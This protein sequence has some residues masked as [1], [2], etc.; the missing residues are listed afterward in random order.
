MGDHG[1]AVRLKSCVLHAALT[2]FHTLFIP[3]K[4]NPVE[5]QSLK[6]PGFNP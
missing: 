6:A 1:G 5:T 4:L 3:Y 2:L